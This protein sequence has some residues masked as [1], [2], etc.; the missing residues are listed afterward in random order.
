MPL[1]VI[2]NP[3]GKIKINKSYSSINI[4]PLAVV[5]APATYITI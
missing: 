1:Y 2:K 3:N 4:I 5:A